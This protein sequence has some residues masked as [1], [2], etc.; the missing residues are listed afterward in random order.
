MTQ[1]KAMADGAMQWLR[2]TQTQGLGPVG[3]DFAHNSINAVQLYR[4]DNAL[5]IASAGRVYYPGDRSEILSSPKK[6]QSLLS[7]LFKDNRFEGTDV[8]VSAPLGLPNVLSLSFKSTS[9]QEIPRQVMELVKERLGGADNDWLVDYLPVKMNSKNS[10][11]ITV[12]AAAM[13]RQESLVFLQNLQRAGL[14]VHA[15]EIAAQ[16]LQRLLLKIKEPPANCLV[17]N[18]GNHQS[19][20]SHFS[21]GHLTMDREISLGHADFVAPISQSLGIEQ[22]LGGTLFHS[23]GFGDKAEISPLLEHTFARLR[24]QIERMNHYIASQ[25]HGDGIDCIYLT[26]E[27]AHWPGATGAFQAALGFPIKTLDPFDVLPALDGLKVMENSRALL[28]VATGLA[29]RGRT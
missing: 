12:M 4:Q 18:V 19:Y 17:L 11:D 27:A 24:V 14:Y 21:H 13:P 1:A 5:S 10:Q 29:M 20:I 26:G 28:S 25:L 7:K 22:T 6:L 3:L 15:Y 23:L 9:A 16:G 2:K 8:A